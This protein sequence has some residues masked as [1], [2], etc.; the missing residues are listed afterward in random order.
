[1]ELACKEGLI[2]G[3]FD[4]RS[5]DYR[6]VVVDSFSELKVQLRF[7]RDVEISVITKIEEL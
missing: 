7:G 3:F 6:D 1:M 4:F 5:D 2:K